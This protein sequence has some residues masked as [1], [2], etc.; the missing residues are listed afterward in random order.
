MRRN[1]YYR[2][3]GLEL[4]RTWADPLTWGAL[5]GFIVI[6]V[7]GAWLYWRSL[8]PRL[9]N[10]RLFG[11]AYLLAM[12]IAWHAGFARD[13]MSKFDVY[14]ASNF[15][16]VRSLYFAKVSAAVVTVC[17]FCLI[18]F[19][20]AVGTSLGD[21]GYAA[22]YATLFLL[23]SMLAVPALV[24][25]E[26]ALNTRYP[27]PILLLLFFGF[28]GIYSRIGDVQALI[29]LL[30]MSGTIEL[31]PALVRTLVALALAAACYPLFHLRLGGRHLAA[32]LDPP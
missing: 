5:F 25:I 27:V 17:G 15:V 8:P 12:I 13:R 32:I 10:G 3:F 11:E 24:L 4:R 19:L 6:L 14:L 23:A 30:G 20:I 28:L 26:L 29:R 2:L 1:S 9:Q 18:A 16:D 7:V 22:H 31:F 21:F